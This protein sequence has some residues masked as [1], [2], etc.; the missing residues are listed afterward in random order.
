MKPFFERQF[1]SPLRRTWAS[2]YPTCSALITPGAVVLESTSQRRPVLRL[3]SGSSSSVES[4]FE[5]AVS[6]LVL[7]M[8]EAGTLGRPVNLIVSDFWSRPMV[9]PLSGQKLNDQEID[10]ALQGAYR[11]TYGDLMAGWVWCWSQQENRVFAVA[12][13]EVGLTALKEGI[14]QRRG[15]LGSARPFAVDLSD[16]VPSVTSERWLALVDNQSVSLI[17]QHGLDWQYWCVVPY[18]GQNQ[19]GFLTQLEREVACRNDPCREVMVVDLIGVVSMPLVREAMLKVGWSMRVW[20]PVL[21]DAGVGYRLMRAI[22]LG[23]M[24]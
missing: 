23:S 17:R 18:S 8:D 12:W 3:R 21:A 7:L 24:S 14:A 2:L 19:L 20:T 9:L 22:T 13:P 6:D 4:Q 1:L 5:A 11:R 15:V 10:A 16:G